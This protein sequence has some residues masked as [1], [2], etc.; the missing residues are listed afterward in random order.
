MYYDLIHISYV[1]WVC[2]KMKKKS[3]CIVVIYD[4]LLIES[5]RCI[6]ATRPM[7]F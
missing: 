1:I 2:T 4:Y 3:K 6:R 7:S 5:M